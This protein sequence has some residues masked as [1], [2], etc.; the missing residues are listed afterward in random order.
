[1]RKRFEVQLILGQT[2][3]E[4]VI[5]PL[6]SRDELPP[7]LASLKWIFTTPEINEEVFE[8][9]ESK[10]TAGKKQTGRP[11]MD[12]WQILVLGVCRMALDCNYDRLEDMANHHSLIRQI[13][14]L[15]VEMEEN[16]K[17]HYK[18]LSDNVAHVDEKLLEQINE[19]VIRHGRTKLK[20]NVT[21]KIQAKTDSYVL[22]TNVH[23]PTDI[24]LL[25]DAARKSIDLLGRLCNEVGVAGWRKAD[26][27]KT[28]IKGLMR[29]LQQTNRGGKNREQR[30]QK[31]ARRYLKK[32]KDLSKK[33][34]ED[35]QT[36]KKAC[37][38]PIQLIN[39]EQVQYF[40][41]ML[42]KHI[43]LLERRVLKEEI[44]P[45]EEKVFSLFEDHTE[46]IAKGKS[47][48]SVELGHRILVTTD[49]Y[50]LVI[51]Y[52]VMEG[53][54]DNQEIVALA[55]R[56][57]ER[58]EEGEIE[59]LS[60][61]KGFSDMNK[62][63][64]LEKLIPMVVMPKKGRRNQADEEREKN[65][66]FKRLKRRHS[67][68]ESNINALEHHGL[69]RCPDKGLSGYKRYV[70]M[71]VLAYNLHRIGRALLEEQRKA[72]ACQPMAA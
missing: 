44:I 32:A 17:F 3:I 66:Q 8:L 53:S 38:N 34:A 71:G 13:M 70:G 15:P 39:L 48:P 18:T 4:K 2:P 55:Q 56:L 10:V 21:E 63:E 26:H 64:E 72:L 41:G 49:Q 62:L 50:G 23:F 46:W 6:K 42:D 35:I 31:A 51:D 14:G 60:M 22:E 57:T 47:R 24:N 65:P 27:W 43:D 69:N 36:V 54:V 52:K 30:R 16:S 25:W 68:V 45:H 12:L 20:K 40:S 11:G 7:T 37:S 61:D 59:S 28:T 58:F 67:A 33:V 1:M 9:L 19:I 5:I 29:Q